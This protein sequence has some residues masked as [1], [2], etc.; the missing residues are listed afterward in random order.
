MGLY[1]LYEAVTSWVDY[2]ENNQTAPPWLNL[3]T[4]CAGVFL[5]H[6]TLS[7]QVDVQVGHPRSEQLKRNQ[8]AKLNQE[9]SRTGNPSELTED[10]AKD[11]ELTGVY[12]LADQGK[13]AEAIQ[14]YCNKTGHPASVGKG[15]VA[16]YLQGQKSG[17]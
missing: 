5:V 15:Y 10:F 4:G 9:A 6:R 14:L 17:A 3:L 16:R 1:W 12:E 11:P 2:F 7:A 8:T 13:Y